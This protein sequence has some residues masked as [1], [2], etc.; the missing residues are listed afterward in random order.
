MLPARIP[1]ENVAGFGCV[2]SV[3]FVIL[4]TRLCQYPQLESARHSHPLSSLMKLPK[5]SA[6]W[7]PFEKDMDLDS[8]LM[9]A[10]GKDV[11]RT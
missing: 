11:S 1:G 7:K 5:S 10:N 6:V 9:W 2:K 3:K 8:V 4:P